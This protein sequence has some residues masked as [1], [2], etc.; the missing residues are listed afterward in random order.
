MRTI[1]T[2][3]A[4]AGLLAGCANPITLNALHQAQAACKTGITDAC[5]AAKQYQ[6]QAD[7]ERQDSAKRALITAVALPIVILGA[8]AAAHA[9]QPDEVI[10]IRQHSWR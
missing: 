4:V 5:D 8:A 3:L 7:A 1:T 2:F 9:N 6:A 10:I